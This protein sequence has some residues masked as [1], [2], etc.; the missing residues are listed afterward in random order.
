MAYS[1]QTGVPPALALFGTIHH[2]A[3]LKL[4][5]KI[6]G[7]RWHGNAG[8]IALWWWTGH[9][10]TPISSRTR[11]VNITHRTAKEAS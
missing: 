1:A 8:A 5:L 3:L 6:R 4:Y 11:C 7:D 9:T 10:W 2:D